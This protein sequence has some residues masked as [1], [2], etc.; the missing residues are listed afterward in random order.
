MNN[1]IDTEEPWLLTGSPRCDPFSQIQ[2][3]NEGRTD[4]AKRS[5]H[6]EEGRVGLRVAALVYTKQHK[7]GRYFL[8]EH[9][10]RAE[11]WHEDIM[12]ELSAQEGVMVTTA[13]QC[14]Y[15]LVTQGPHGPAPAQL[16]RHGHGITCS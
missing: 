12:K 8:H 1:L 11:S 15:G 13:D 4:P 16:S 5:R 10:H 6:L 3:I 2:F 7:C 9:P 14:A